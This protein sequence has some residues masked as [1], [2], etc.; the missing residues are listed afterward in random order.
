M[1][2]YPSSLAL[3]VL[4]ALVLTAPAF[5]SEPLPPI[6]SP[7]AAGRIVQYRVK[8]GDTV[9]SIARALGAKL[10]DVRNANGGDRLAVGKTL[11]IAI[12]GP[13]PRPTKSAKKSPQAPTKKA[14][15]KKAPPAPRPS[16]P[17]QFAGQSSGS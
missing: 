17:A 13:A 8:K 1:N 12:T 14:T 11:T 16:V 15:A 4:S 7:P 5:A 3:A 6:F 10:A 2:R 9:S